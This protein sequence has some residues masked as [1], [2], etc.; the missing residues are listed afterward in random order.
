VT[1]HEILV[2]GRDLLSNPDHWIKKTLARSKNGE[3]CDPTEARA[4]CFCTIGAIHKVV[5]SGQKSLKLEVVG[6]LIKALDERKH[7]VSAIVVAFNDHPTTKH[8]DVLELW[9]KA[10]ELARH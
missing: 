1:P 5:G 4:T 2:A 10:I 6:Y 9:D 7:R 3:K 8:S